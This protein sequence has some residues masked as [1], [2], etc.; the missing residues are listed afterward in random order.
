MGN[1]P[2]PGVKRPGCGTVHPLPAS[3]EV[4]ER[5][6]LYL[7]SP[8]GASS[9]V[10]GWALLYFTV[11]LQIETIL[12]S[13]WVWILVHLELCTRQWGEGTWFT[14]LLTPWSRVL[15][16]KLTGSE[17]SQA[18]LHILWKP[19]VHYHIHK[20]PPPAPILSQLHPVS[21]PSHFLKIYLNIVLPS[22]SG[23]P[24]WQYW[25]YYMI[26][27]KHNDYSNRRSPSTCL[28]HTQVILKRNEIF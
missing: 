6:E 11:I 15:L 22:T 26:T 8:F 16:E 14:Y 28:S 2:C 12:K 1:G 25:L 21:T 7:Y 27:C 24:Q 23:S 4:K 20:C 10:P 9:P 18:I 3:T 17:S 5:V 19:K 13:T